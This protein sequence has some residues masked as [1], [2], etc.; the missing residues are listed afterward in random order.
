MRKLRQ[1]WL[2]GCIVATFALAPIVNFPVEALATTSLASAKVA[3]FSPSTQRLAGNDRY[4]TAEQIAQEGWKS[5]SD[6]AVLTAGMD[7]NLVDALAAAPLAKLHNAP[8]LLTEGNV[9]N[10]KAEA[11]IKRLGVKTVYVTTG[12][13][14]IKS[15]VTDRLTELG[16]NTIMLGGSDRFATAVN[17]AKEIASVKPFTQIAVTTAWKNADALSVAS[18]AAAKGFPILLSDVNSLPQG[19]ADYI[20][21]LRD[22]ISDTYVLGSETVIGQSVENALPKPTR[23]GGSDRYA[24]N[25]EILKTF[26]RDI[27]HGKVFVASGEDNHL[28]DALSVSPLAGQNLAP[29]VL[30]GQTMPPETTDFVKKNLLPNQLIALGGESAVPSPS[31]QAL[32]TFITYADSSVTEGSEDATAP[33]TIAD[34]LIISG[35]NVTLQNAK[36]TDSIYVQGD[37]AVLKNLDVTG[38]IFL[39]P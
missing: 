30:T 38:T 1:K 7:E 23:V 5:T 27:V 10:S 24:T 8:I 15:A 25:R 12:S 21:S 26:A 20:N 31:L 9:L 32:T 18:F 13:T 29:V 39:D 2:T 22:S 36:E 33:V 34:T 17:I 11:E 3:T 19:T 35:D 6:Y 37:K 14:V 28:V 16:V 4:G